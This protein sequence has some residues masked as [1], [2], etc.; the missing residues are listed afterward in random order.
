MDKWDI[1]IVVVGCVACALFGGMAGYNIGTGTQPPPDEDFSRVT[2]IGTVMNVEKIDGENHITLDTFVGGVVILP[3]NVI[4]EI[5]KRYVFKY[6]KDAD[7]YFSQS[8]IRVLA[9]V[10][11]EEIR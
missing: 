8:G 6:Y 11:L 7:L 9:R 1:V 3:G 2:I 10:E 4:P 5:G